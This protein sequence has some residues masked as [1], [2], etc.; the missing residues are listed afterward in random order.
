MKSYSEQSIQ[1]Y[2]FNKKQQPP[3]I[4]QGLLFCKKQIAQICTKLKFVQNSTKT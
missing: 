1:G 4:H 3:L 2:R